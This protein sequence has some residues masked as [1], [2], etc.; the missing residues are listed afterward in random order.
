LTI[1]GHYLDH[2]KYRLPVLMDRFS[3][4]LEIRDKVNRKYI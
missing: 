4:R 3:R 2:E 1:L